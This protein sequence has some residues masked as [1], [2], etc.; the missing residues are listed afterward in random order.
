MRA[1]Q[2]QIIPRL[3]A[4]CVMLYEQRRQQGAVIK[5]SEVVAYCI[6]HL[7]MTE[8]NLTTTLKLLLPHL[9]RVGVFPRKR[10]VGKE[11]TQQV[12]QQVSQHG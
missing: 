5:P 3:T 2:R 11:V 9:R 10:R 1:S 8:P 4:T 6:E 12:S 7:G